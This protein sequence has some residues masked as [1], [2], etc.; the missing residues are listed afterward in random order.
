[1][2][3]SLRT[4]SSLAFG[5]IATVGGLRLLADVEVIPTYY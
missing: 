4:Y 1:M 2:Y 3:F 5:D